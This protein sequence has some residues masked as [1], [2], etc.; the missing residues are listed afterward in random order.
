MPEVTASKWVNLPPFSHWTPE[1]VLVFGIC[2]S[3]SGY[4]ATAYQI[5]EPRHDQARRKFRGYQLQF[6][7]FIFG[8]TEARREE[9][10]F[11]WWF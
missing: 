6:C 5:S 8:E 4:N 11:H 2:P 3:V 9:A 10:L 7:Y 1:R